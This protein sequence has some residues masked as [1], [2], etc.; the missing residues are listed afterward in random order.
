MGDSSDRIEVTTDLMC[1]RS[2]LHVKENDVDFGRLRGDE[3]IRVFS[4]LSN[5]HRLR[6]L[7][8]LAQGQGRI[9]VSL[10]AREV[11]LSRPLVH[12][13]LQRLERAGLV[14]GHLELSDD[15][16]AMKFF[17]VVPFLLRL[18]PEV[19]AKAAGTLTE[20]EETK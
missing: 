4:A 18:S 1:V 19:A 11:G 17:E 12:M 3:L 7:A 10:L 13:H 14:R 8:A 9:H 20:S 6:I 5:P 16:K 2:D 15:G